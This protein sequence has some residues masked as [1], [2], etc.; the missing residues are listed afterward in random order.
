MGKHKH[1]ACPCPIAK[2]KQ[3]QKSCL[4]P[5]GSVGEL[6]A[7]QSW[8]VVYLHVTPCS[9]PDLLGGLG[10]ALL[11]PADKSVQEL[12]SLTREATS[13]QFTASVSAGVKQE[14]S[15]LLG[16]QALRNQT[17]EKA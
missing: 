1:Q 12:M 4:C 5:C 2:D 3:E 17:P 10:H 6:L 14:L 15:A 7:V 8:E 13:D 11:I 16:W 9:A